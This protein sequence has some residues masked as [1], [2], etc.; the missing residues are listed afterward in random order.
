M[1][2][3]AQLV[4]TLRFHRRGVPHCRFPARTPCLP[5]SGGSMGLVTGGLFN[6]VPIAPKVRMPMAVTARPDR[7]L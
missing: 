7:C 1:T 6:L 3:K 2:G 5:G 4:R